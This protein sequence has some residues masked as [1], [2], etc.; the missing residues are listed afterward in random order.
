[1]FNIKTFIKSTLVLL[2][3]DLLYL[4]INRETYM[5]EIY[6]S[7][8]SK[9][10]LK[11]EGVLW[12]YLSQLIGLNYFV[13]GKENEIS[14]AFIY[15]LVIYGNYLGTNYATIRIFDKRLARSDLLKGI[16]LMILTTYLIQN[17]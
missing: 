2:T 7:Q 6:R 17:L 3:L 10:D 16:T 12:R 11:W 15:G 14:R 5:R 1:M 8:G 9:L 4:Y 13:L